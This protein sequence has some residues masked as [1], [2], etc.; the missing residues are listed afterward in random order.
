M[1]SVS[2]KFKKMGRYIIDLQDMYLC[3]T[4]KGSLHKFDFSDMTVRKITT[5]SSAASPI[6]YDEESESIMTWKQR[7]WQKIEDGQQAIMF[8][9]NHRIEAQL[10]EE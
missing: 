10:L 8:M 9:F 7:R 2:N 1:R 6:R 3:D 5:Q 4:L